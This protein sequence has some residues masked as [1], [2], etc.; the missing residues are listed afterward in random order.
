MVTFDLTDRHQ[1]KPPSG[2]CLSTDAKPFV[3]VMNGTTLYEMDTK[4]V[5]MF[6]AETE[7]WLEQ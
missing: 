2:Y 1:G 6:D 3:G 7:S 4:K 5:Y